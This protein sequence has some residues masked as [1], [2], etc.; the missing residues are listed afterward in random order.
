MNI[1]FPVQNLLFFQVNFPILKLTS[2]F[3]FQIIQCLIECLQK[4]RQCLLMLFIW[5]PRQN[6]SCGGDSEVGGRQEALERSYKWKTNNRFSLCF[7]LHSCWLPGPRLCWCVAQQQSK[8][9]I[10]LAVSIRFN[11]S[12]RLHLPESLDCVTVYWWNQSGA[13]E[14][15]YPPRGSQAPPEGNRSAHIC[16]E[17]WV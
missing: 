14:S 9:I 12:T 8:V 10:S 3:S 11:F 16:L 5:M 2:C 7:P 15:L 13:A 4:G 6:S 1:I 17:I